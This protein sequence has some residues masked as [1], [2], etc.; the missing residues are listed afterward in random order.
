MSIN[1]IP[2][3]HGNAVDMLLFSERLRRMQYR[4]DLHDHRY[5]TDIYVL[6]KAKRLTHLVLHHCKYV[7]ELVLKVNDWT[8]DW[9]KTELNGWKRFE[10][11]AIDG[12]I[13]CMSM[14]NVMGRH[15][16]ATFATMPWER[17]ELQKA[18]ITA[19]GKMAKTI[20][21]IDHLNQTNPLHELVNEVHVLFSCYSHCLKLV[22]IPFHTVTDLMHDRLLE[23]ESK[24]MWHNNYLD[25]IDALMDAY[26]TERIVNG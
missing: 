25:E 24:H 5:H 23:V 18:M 8:P 19:I 1:P 6:P 22:G 7:S 21:D 20:E 15:M 3:E 12:L 13:V 10:R 4:Q 11:V 9:R 16:A 14:S 17:G 2:V 26:D